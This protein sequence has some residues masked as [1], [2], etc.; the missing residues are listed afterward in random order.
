MPNSLNFH[1]VDV[2]TTRRFCG[3]PLA[4]VPNADDLSGEQMLQITREFN[5]SET[6]FVQ[7]PDD[8]ENNAKVRIFFPAGEIPFAGHPTVGCAIFLAERQHTGGEDFETTIVLE[9]VAG[10]VPVEVIRRGGVSEAR[11][12]A[13]ILPAPAKGVLPGPSLCADALGLAAKDIGF[14]QHRIGLYE[15]GPGFLYVPV[16]SRQLLSK[17][18]VHEPA[19]SRM[20]EA[21]GVDCGYLYTPGPEPNSFQSRL[22]APAAGIPEDPAT[23]SATAI[24][25]GQ[26]HASGALSEGSHHFRLRQGIEMGRPSELKLEVDVSRGALSRVRVA[27]SSVPVSSGQMNLA[28]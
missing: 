22:F 14:G 13:P 5:L 15:G 28:D 19:W 2:F 9:E 6:I 23:G 27:G 4:I 11:F 21:A 20:I 24:L 25:A 17:A 26:L 16:A 3:N 7:T 1:T 8:P 12:V 10:L 18:A